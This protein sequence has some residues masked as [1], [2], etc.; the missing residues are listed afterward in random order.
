MQV[1]GELLTGTRPQKA[2][3]RSPLLTSCRLMQL[4]FAIV[5]EGMRSTSWG[6]G[7]LNAY[8]HSSTQ[9]RWKCDLTECNDLCVALMRASTSSSRSSCHQCRAGCLLSSR[10]PEDF[11]YGCVGA[12]NQTTV[13]VYTSSAECCASHLH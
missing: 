7:E 12:G 2:C 6:K 8:V 10:I 9:L 5:E 13:V 11:R 1:H 4:Q 3:S